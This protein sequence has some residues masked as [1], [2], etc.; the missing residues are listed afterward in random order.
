MKKRLFILA[1]FAAVLSSAHAQPE[2]KAYGSMPR[3]GT[4]IHGVVRDS[5]GP[6]RAVEVFEVNKEKEVVAYTYSDKNGHFSLE[7]VNRENGKFG[8][9]NTSGT[10]VIPIEFDELYDFN[11]AGNV[12]FGKKESKDRILYG[13]MSNKGTQILPPTFDFIS[14]FINHH[15]VVCKDGKYGVVDSLGV[16]RIPVQFDRI[17]PYSLHD[18]DKSGLV[19]AVSNGKTGFVDINTGMVSIPFIYDDDP[20]GIVRFSEGFCALKKDGEYVCIDMT[21]NE[22]I[23]AG[24]KYISEFNNGTATATKGSNTYV[25]DTG[26]NEIT[27]LGNVRLLISDGRILLAYYGDS[28]WKVFDNYGIE[29]SQIKCQSLSFWEQKNLLVVRK[30]NLLKKQVVFITDIYGQP[31]CRTVFQELGIGSDENCPVK[32]HGKWGGRRIHCVTA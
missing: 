13:I 15:A 14:S 22:C 27:N 8:A 3:K 12:V 29:L 2:I 18:T 11:S 28:R 16:I 1:F 21:G 26:G 7:L 30:K 24:W 10:L 23:R 19:A 20:V 6:A 31:I 5:E 17:V 32:K 9:I 4:V 25:I